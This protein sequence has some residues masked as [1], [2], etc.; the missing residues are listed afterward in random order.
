MNNTTQTSKVFYS[1][2]SDNPNLNRLRQAIRDAIDNLNSSGRFKAM[3]EYDEATRNQPGSPNIV[4]SL[5]GKILDASI[6]ICDLSLC[7]TAQNNKATKMSPNPNV[8][9]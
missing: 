4:E 6:F 3:L 1:W 7:Y 8:V 2:S 9:F 5:K